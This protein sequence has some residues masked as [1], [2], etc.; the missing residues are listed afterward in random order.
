MPFIE[1]NR[2]ISETLLRAVINTAV[3]GIMV[4]DDQGVVHLYNAACERLFGYSAAEVIGQNVKILMPTPYRDEHDGY[5]EAYRRTGNARIIGIGREVVGQR[6]DGSRFPIGLSVGKA[7]YKDQQFFVGIVHDVSAQKL[8][9]EKLRRAKE[10]AEAANRAKSEF[11][12]VMSHEIRTPLHGILGTVGLLQHAVSK[13]KHNQ[14]AAT[15]Q[16][17]CEGLLE[18]VDTILD[19]SKIESGTV[20]LKQ[21]N[22]EIRDLLD[23]VEFL[24]EP[25]VR[26]KELEYFTKIAHDVP[27]E[28]IG[29][30]D[31]IREILNNLVCNAVR[32]TEEGYIA[33]TAQRD[34]AV[35]ATEDGRMR[36]R[37]EVKDTGVGINLED[38]ARLFERFEQGDTSLTRQYGGSGLGLAICKHLSHLLGGEIGVVSEPNRG[39]RFWFTITCQTKLSDSQN[40]WNSSAVLT[41]ADVES[42]R[43]G[44]GRP[45]SLSV[46][47]A[48]DNP[49]NQVIIRDILEQNGHDVDIAPNGR[50]AVRAVSRGRYDL[51]LMDIRMPIMDGLEATRK[52]RELLAGK[53]HTHI[54]A[55]TA[56]AMNGVREECL[57]AGMDD[58]ISKPFTIA[59]INEVLAKYAAAA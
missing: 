13:K 20:V 18:I 48:E 11:L 45:R 59:Q 15:I 44:G 28:I 56:H 10:D 3:D 6:K 33:V 52:I 32:F 8:T 57:E 46:L 25:R 47:V 42:D 50:E 23:S 31:R 34:N 26:E 35:P 17:S 39:S 1:Q 9:E 19:L 37:F 36:L 27:P 2:H 58:Y 51:I 41:G 49:T 53:P 55:L 12:A 14:Y 43:S 24:W 40:V 29:D 54:I 38:Q 16:Q 5:I 30:A 4:I 7:W 21:T 22:F